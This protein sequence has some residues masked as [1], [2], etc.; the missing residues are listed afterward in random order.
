MG[1]SITQLRM[2]PAPLRLAGVGECLG[3]GEGLFAA[4]EFR[5]EGDIEG[6]LGGGTGECGELEKRLIQ[7][8]IGN[9]E[10]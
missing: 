9:A 3:R 6:E 8:I 4:R 2:R 7:H 5:T 1:W 10:F